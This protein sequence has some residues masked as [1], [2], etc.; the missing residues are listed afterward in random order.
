MRRCSF[1]LVP[2]LAIMAVSLPCSAVDFSP[3]YTNINVDGTSRNF[4]YYV[5][6]SY[7]PSKQTPLLFMFHGFGGNNSEAS[8]GSAENGYYGWQT[9]AHENGFIVFFPLGTG[10]LPWGFGENSDDLDFI[11]EMIVWA[12]ANYNIRETHI[13]T[14]GHSYGAMF[15]Y[16]AARWRGDVI[17]AF[18]AHS[19]NRST[20][21]PSGPNP[22]P[23]LNG[24]L[25]QHL[26]R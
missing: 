6:E 24:I 12:K 13:F 4:G 5:P 2:I 19:G 3:A 20:A 25:L 16:A 21:V 17:A 15:S 7:D 9:S 18:G 11:D 10:F 1:G 23:K 26:L 22:T 8:G 14:T